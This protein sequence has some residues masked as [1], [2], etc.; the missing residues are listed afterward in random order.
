M[1]KAG[2]QNNPAV[3]AEMAGYISSEVDRT[4]NLISRFLN[5]ARPLELHPE[6]A[7]VVA[8]VDQAIQKS[9]EQAEA[10]GVQIKRESSVSELPF[11]GDPQLLLLALQN[12]IQNAVQLAAP[13]KP[14]G[15]VSRTPSRPGG[16][17]AGSK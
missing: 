15:S 13:G 6:P 14:C 7:H 17:L 16:R 5:F 10:R 3:M 1:T 9:L 12:L 2:T 4:S 8:I 11:V